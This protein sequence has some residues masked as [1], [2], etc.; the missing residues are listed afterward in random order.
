MKH[1]FFY[2][3]NVDNT[4]YS[5]LGYSKK[6]SRWLTILSTNRFIT[7]LECNLFRG[8]VLISILN[9]VFFNLKHLRVDCLQGTYFS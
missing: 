3:H 2:S 8:G 6:S 7:G 1:V 4:E 5:K 9:R